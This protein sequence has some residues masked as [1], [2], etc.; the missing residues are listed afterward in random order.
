LRPLAEDSTEL[1]DPV[2]KRNV[3]EYTSSAFEYPLQD[4]GVEEPGRLV[5]V[6]GAQTK[7]SMNAFPVGNNAQP[8]AD[9]SAN[10]LATDVKSYESECQPTVKLVNAF[11]VSS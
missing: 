2:S 11:D 3:K 7:S 10:E 6:F 1:S 5:V 8:L 9:G 4:G